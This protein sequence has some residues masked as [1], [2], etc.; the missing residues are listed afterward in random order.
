MIFNMSLDDGVSQNC[1]MA[2]IPPVFKKGSRHDPGNYRPVSLTSHVGKL[3][4]IRDEM[5]RHLNE[6]KLINKSQHGFMWK[7]SCLTNL[8][9]FLG[10]ITTR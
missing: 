3:S 6:N 1:K 7:R 2:N 4:L 5:V 8:L 10:Y 9:E